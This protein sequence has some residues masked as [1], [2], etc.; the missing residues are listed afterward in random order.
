ML[1]KFLIYI[2]L[3]SGLCTHTSCRWWPDAVSGAT[4]Q[5]QSG[6]NNYYSQEEATK[7][8]G[9]DRIF[10]L[11]EVPYNQTVK[12]KRIPYRSV[13]V[14]EARTSGDAVIFEGL[15]R[16][17]GYALCDILSGIKVDKESKDDFY[18]PGDLYIEVRN[19][20]GETAVFSWG[21]I[22]YAANMYNIIIAKYVTRVVPGKTGELWT[23][24]K[25]T[26]LV[27]GSDLL[28]ERNIEAPTSI[29]ICSLKGNYIVDQSRTEPS[30]TL[31]FE[32]ADGSYDAVD[33]Q[34]QPLMLPSKQTYKNVLYGHGMGYKGFG[35]YNGWR[36]CDVMAPYYDVLARDLRTGMLSVEGLDG[37]RASMS[38]SEVMN[39][40]DHA[41]VILMHGGDK[42]EE[43]G[44]EGFSIYAG[45]DMM[46]DRAVKGLAKIRLFHAKEVINTELSGNLIIFHAGSLSLPIKFMADTFMLIHP[47]VKVLSEAAGS[48][49]C[50]RKITELHRPCDI[51]ASADYEVIERLLIP[52]YAHEN[53]P[54]ARN[55]MAVVY[56]SKSKYAHEVNAHNWKEILL[57]PD[58]YMGRADPNADPCGYRTLLT[59]KLAG[60]EQ[61]M[62]AK[63][64]QFMR[65]KEVELLALL[66][67]GSLDYI[68]L[69]KS[70]AL[71]HGLPYVT[72]PDSVNLSNI[73]LAEHYA[74]VG[75]YVRGN[76]PLDSIYIQGAPMVYSFAVLK[77]AP[78]PKVA[79]A[80]AAFL[81][82]PQG[83]LAIMKRMGQTPIEHP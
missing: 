13:A 64:N 53:R 67:S 71:Q 14:R 28:S 30:H 40:N 17:D 15:F 16:Y 61:E 1:K 24:P 18:P 19:D 34:S 51:M 27:V 20:L 25:K 26:K 36:L 2:L 55:E 39:R 54:F 21:E 31:I 11:G 74:T 60:C 22:F 62:L 49:D 63:K 29:T 75:L 58:V 56:S 9:P 81:T 65:P 6:S 69:Y 37:Y 48:L 38:F 3:L 52:K 46:V 59:L 7:L 4:W 42:S 23:L 57:R 79:K 76:T 72:L 83:G 41:E 82:D 10:V 44:R 78:N 8:Q 12:L 32:Q 35:N 45:N 5:W 73:D 66:E 47:K 43:P 50:A 70:V 80:F 77:D 68:F 33:A